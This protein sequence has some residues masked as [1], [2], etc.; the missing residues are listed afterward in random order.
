MKF[1]LHQQNSFQLRKLDVIRKKG[2]E[3]TIHSTIVVWH[4]DTPPDQQ[5]NKLQQEVRV[6]PW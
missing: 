3:E 1:I 6:E 5:V 4:I 2:E